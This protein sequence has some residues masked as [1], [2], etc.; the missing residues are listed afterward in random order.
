MM[1]PSDRLTLDREVLAH[2]QKVV[3]KGNDWVRENRRRPGGCT[4]L[5]SMVCI[6]QDRFRDNGCKDI[7][8]QLC[9][10]KIDEKNSFKYLDS[11]QLLTKTEF[12]CCPDWG[13]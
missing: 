5:E 13:I 9:R 12:C 1:S 2:S 7:R 6:L 11:H 10:D 8:C 3:T 4:S